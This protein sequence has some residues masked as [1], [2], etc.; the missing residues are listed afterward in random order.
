[1]ESRQDLWKVTQ[2]SGYVYILR[3]KGI[4]DSVSSAVWKVPLE[5]NISFARFPMTWTPPCLQHVK[6]YLK[7]HVMV[8]STKGINLNHRYQACFRTAAST[9]TDPEVSRTYFCKKKKKTLNLMG[10]YNSL[11]E[12]EHIF[13]HGHV[14]VQC[15]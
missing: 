10:S 3:T 4:C 9:Y 11:E 13:R 8:A 12:E 14:L 15:L 5:L 6:R 7:N 2:A 1:M